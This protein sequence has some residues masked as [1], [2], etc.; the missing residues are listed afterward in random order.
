MV[1]VVLST[2][3]LTSSATSNKD[4]GTQSVSMSTKL[5]IGKAKHRASSNYGSSPRIMHSL[6][7]SGGANREMDCRCL[8]K[9]GPY[10]GTP[11]SNPRG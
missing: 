3:K 4:V 9:I 11:T 5:I 10:Y 1:L 2:S 7:A 8:F 6:Q